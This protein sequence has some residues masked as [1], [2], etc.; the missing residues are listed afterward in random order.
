M[1]RELLR[2]A[3]IY[4]AATLVLGAAA[5]VAPGRHLAW[6]GK[7]FEPPQAGS[8]FIFIDAGSANALRA[9]LP[10]VVFLDTRAAADVAAGR[11]PGA[12]AIA[13]TDLARQ[14]QRPLLERLRAADAVIIYGGS[15]EADVEQLLAQELRR[16]GLAP[17]HV[18]VG[19]F[20]AW[21]AGGLPVESAR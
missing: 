15:D 18:L 13:Y 4:L 21:L 8:D 12:L 16:Y 11:V 20:A 9:S 3:A 2:D 17:P 7:G 19:G 1:S 10:R 14:L 6:W 5:N